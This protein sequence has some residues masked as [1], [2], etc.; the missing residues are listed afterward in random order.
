[1]VILIIFI[2][3]NVRGLLFPAP[4]TLSAR[5]AVRGAGQYIKLRLQAGTTSPHDWVIGE[6]WTSGT[7]LQ[8]LAC[9]EAFLV[10]KF[11]QFVSA[12]C[13]FGSCER[14]DWDDSS[15]VHGSLCC[16][17]PRLSRFPNPRWRREFSA[18]PH[19]CSARYANIRFRTLE[20]CSIG[21]W[22]H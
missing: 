6:Q 14:G 9:N 22:T 19:A 5:V 18:C 17:H 10:D 1:M 3:I 16:T 11:I 15:P 4:M 20:S 8:T 12:D 7:V 21:K 13:H 2:M